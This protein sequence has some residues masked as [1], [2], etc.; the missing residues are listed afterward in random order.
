[1]PTPKVKT[2]CLSLAALLTVVLA[3]EAWWSNRSALVPAPKEAL[4]EQQKGAP[5]T[6][7]R[8]AA[9]VSHAQRSALPKKSIVAARLE[10]PPGF[11]ML[12][13]TTDP[14]SVIAEMKPSANAGTPAAIRVTGQALKLCAI[15]KKL[16]SDEQMVQSVAAA[17]MNIEYL[18][19]KGHKLVLEGQL[20]GTKIQDKLLDDAKKLAESCRSVS[21]E[22]AN[23]WRDWLKKASDLGD[24]RATEDLAMANWQDSRDKDLTMEQ[25]D[26][27]ADAAVD[28]A[29]NEVANGNC[30]SEEVTVLTYA[31]KDPLVTY[32]YGNVMLNRGLRGLN[33][34]LPEDQQRELDFIQTRQRELA[35]AV[36]PERMPEANQQLQYVSKNYCGG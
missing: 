18:E 25:R 7:T 31:G 22:D 21:T 26:A 1:M 5:K 36:P 16:G 20:E 10:N 11:P 9:T 14:A 33:T 35:A 17:S 19:K 15:A 34:L 2:V 27:A 24:I 28:L 32:V 3:G 4:A 6:H 29:L 12:L 30:N 13:R 23:A 8:P